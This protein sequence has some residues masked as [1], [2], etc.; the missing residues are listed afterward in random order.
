[1]VRISSESDRIGISQV[2]NQTGSESDRF[3]IRYVWDQIG[4]EP[5]NVWNLWCF[6]EGL[7]H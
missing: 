5:I 3:G 6:N 2:W 4:S 1:L 7:K